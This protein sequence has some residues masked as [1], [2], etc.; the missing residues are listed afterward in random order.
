MAFTLL[1]FGI[2]ATLLISAAGWLTQSI[3]M[4]RLSKDVETFKSSLREHEIRFSRLHEKRAEVIAELYSHL[5]D[6]VESIDL[7]YPSWA[8]INLLHDEKKLIQM[9]H[10]KS[11]K[12]ISYFDK[13]RIYFSEEL[14]ALIDIFAKD[15]REHVFR[16]ELFKLDEKEKVNFDQAMK[17]VKEQIP[18]AMKVIEAEFRIL[19]GVNGRS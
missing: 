7:L 6:S 1:D 18:Q 4:H 12:L 2:S 11:Y 8:P 15:L 14:V 9:A 13:N 10:D 19:L 16:F 5:T 3:I 17:N